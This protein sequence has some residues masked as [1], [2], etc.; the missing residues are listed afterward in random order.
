MRTM[1]AFLLSSKP[2][3]LR[4]RQQIVKRNLEA[5]LKAKEIDETT[6]HPLTPLSSIAGRFYLLTKIHKAHVP[7]RPITSG[8]GTVTKNISLYVDSLINRTS[9][10]FAS[11]IR[12]PKYFLPETLDFEIPSGCL[13]CH[14]IPIF[15]TRMEY[16]RGSTLPV[17]HGSLSQSRI[18]HHPHY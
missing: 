7:G 13:P 11:F 10:N 9:P 15:P 12:D 16:K 14:C 8:I 17:N 3:W 1:P 4:Q 2:W 6:V 5:L 18:L